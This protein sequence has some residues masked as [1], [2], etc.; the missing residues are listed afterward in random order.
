MNQICEFLINYY[1]DN[2]IT[3][4]KSMITV[5]CIKKLNMTSK[6]IVDYISK[7]LKLR[8][9]PSISDIEEKKTPNKHSIT[10]IY[11]ENICEVYLVEFNKD[12]I[13]WVLEYY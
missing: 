2:G 3:E 9:K 13:Y 11:K 10:F 1:Q 6:Q 5:K 7:Q 12:N 4:K 8:L